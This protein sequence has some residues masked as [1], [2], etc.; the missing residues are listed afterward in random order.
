[1]STLIALCGCVAS[2][3]SLNKA[4][5]ESDVRR[6]TTIL[7]SGADPNGRDSSG[8]TPLFYALHGV[9]E[10][11]DQMLNL[12]VASGADLELDIDN[13]IE[14]DIA[15][16]GNQGPLWH[17]GNALLH[18]LDH[19]DAGN[20]KNVFILIRSGSSLDVRDENGLTPLHYATRIDNF[21]Q[22]QNVIKALLAAGADP[23]AQDKFGKTPFDYINE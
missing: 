1:M 3:D 2:Q 11:V 22:R 19:H 4:I 10:S 21:N 20:Y 14:A 12:L 23:T 18:S 15:E 17:G 13:D 9:S 6:V 5:E 8:R 16:H 7:D